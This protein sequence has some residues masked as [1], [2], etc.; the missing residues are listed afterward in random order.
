MLSYAS[1]RTS[2]PPSGHC[3]T[4]CSARNSH[5]RRRNRNGA[6]S[7]SIP[8]SARLKEQWSDIQRELVLELDQQYGCLRVRRRRQAALGKRL[9]AEY[10]RRQQRMT[11]WPTYPDGKLD[12]R[13]KTFREM[14]GLYPQVKPLRELRYSLSALRLNSLAVGTDNRNRTP[15]G[16]TARR[17]DAISRQTPSTSSARR[18]GSV[19]DQAAA[20]ARP[21]PS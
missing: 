19:S 21:D 11:S 13:D 6:G 17:P 16:H 4:R 2:S 9:F 10:S 14:E 3:R 7:R 12:E 18:N 5:G 8:I 1:C 20:R 15:L